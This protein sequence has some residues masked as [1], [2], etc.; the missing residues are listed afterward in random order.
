MASQLKNSMKVGELSLTDNNKL[1]EIDDTWKETCFQMVILAARH[2]V[3]VCS[4]MIECD[5]FKLVNDNYGHLA[6]D[7]VLK[8][9]A[10]ILSAGSVKV[11]LLSV[12]EVM[13]F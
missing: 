10:R 11:M 4:S 12:M 6:G 3:P 1:K 13:S 2:N 7:F 8:E 9:L 5:F